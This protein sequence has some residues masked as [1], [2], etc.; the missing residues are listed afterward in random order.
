MYCEIK[1]GGNGGESSSQAQQAQQ[2]GE[3]QQDRYKY[4]FDLNLTP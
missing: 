1:Y 4:D 2:T 3:A